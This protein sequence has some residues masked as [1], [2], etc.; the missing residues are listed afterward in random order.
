M[1]NRGRDETVDLTQGAAR[2]GAVPRGG[3]RR[4]RPRR[5]RDHRADRVPARD[6]LSGAEAAQRWARRGMT[7]LA[8]STDLSMLGAA[9]RSTLA[10]LREP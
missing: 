5:D 9:A 2:F 10:V 1:R 3:T 4:R 6:V 7:L 8:I